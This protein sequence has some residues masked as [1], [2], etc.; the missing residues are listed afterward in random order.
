MEKPLFWTGS[1]Q[2]DLRDF[3]DEVKRV[4]GF[5]LWQAQAGG[6]HVSARPLKGFGGG[7]VLE[8][9]EDDDGSTYRAVYTVKFAGAVYVLHAFQKK[10]TRGISTPKREIDLVKQRLRD[11]EAHYLGGRNEEGSGRE[12]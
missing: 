10:S 11:A 12:R 9:V 2:R 4:M 5:A 6:K 1:S 8:L 3:P 7:G